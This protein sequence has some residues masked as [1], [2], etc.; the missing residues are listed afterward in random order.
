MMPGDLVTLTFIPSKGAGIVLEVRPESTVAKIMW[1]Q[2]SVEY[3]GL[4]QLELV[5]SF[6][7]PD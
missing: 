3:W 1:R 6:P 5:Q 4:A 2:G 7:N